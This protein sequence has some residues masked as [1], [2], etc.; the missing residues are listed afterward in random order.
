MKNKKIKTRLLII[1][2]ALSALMILLSLP[3][4]ADETTT[5]APETA[6]G[7]TT[8]ETSAST[9]DSSAGT[10]K[11]AEQ[12][13]IEIKED[14]QIKTSIW[15]Y[16]AV[17]FAYV[18]EF[19]NKICGNNYVIALLLFAI[20]MKLILFPFGIKQQ[21]NMVK[22]ASLRPK[23][24]AI[25]KKYA[26]R[27]DKATQ[28][29]QQQEI[30]DLYQRENYNPASGCLPLLL[31]M[32]ILFALFQVVYNPLRYVKHLGSD[33]IRTVLIGLQKIGF[34]FSTLKVFRMSN[35]TI[36]NFY[37]MYIVQPL[38]DNYE[39]LSNEVQNIIGA[40][41]SLPRF[42]IF[43]INLAETPNMKE[44][45]WYWIIPVLTFICVFLSMKLTRKFSYQPQQEGGAGASLKFMDF[46][47]PLISTWMTFMFPAILGIYWIY[48][49][50]L[51]VV[52]QIVLKKMYPIPEFS[53]EDYAAAEREYFGRE[54][55][56]KEKPV[57]AEGEYDPKKAGGGNKKKPGQSKYNSVMPKGRLP[58]GKVSLHHIDD[59]D[60]IPELPDRPETPE[61]LYNPENTAKNAKKSKGSSLI[62]Q[63]PL[64]DEDNNEENE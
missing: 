64:K 40:K 16:I 18:L 42:Q 60:D 8:A 46:T 39:K 41:S 33:A 52:Q 15:G 25:R 31:Q 1:A 45:S 19:C 13:K 3:V 5:A 56:K 21:K 34:D 30:M 50:L 61:E 55:K 7:E 49:N 51:G 28:Q 26:G 11:K 6:S 37:D 27:T 58:E 2:L 22:Q 53:D 10:E 57:F 63:A 23:E 17:P 4:F 32:P 59:D 20:F 38:T 43:G 36:T 29:K 12:E 62:G 44:I 47:M 48:Q 24:Q 54:K 35:N 9:D 14:T